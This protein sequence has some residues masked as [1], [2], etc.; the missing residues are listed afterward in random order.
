MHKPCCLQMK[1]YGDDAWL[2]I[3]HQWL[4]RGHRTFQ[5]NKHS[6]SFPCG[7][8]T[9]LYT[10]R[11]CEKDRDV[12]SPSYLRTIITVINIILIRYWK[13]VYIANE[14]IK[15]LTN[16]LNAHASGPQAD[17]PTGEERRLENQTPWGQV[18]ATS[19]LCDSSKLLNLTDTCF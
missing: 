13:S 2:M 5:F 1:N 15:Q 14:Y 4:V 16:I 6:W 12:C 10:C 8:K 11:V 9:V 18:P 7:W 3:S 17:M 19:G